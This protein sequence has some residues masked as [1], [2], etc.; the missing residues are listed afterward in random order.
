MSAGEA[1]TEGLAAPET[2]RR[3][4][5]LWTAKEALSKALRCGLTCPVELLATEGA[6]FRGDAVTG[7]FRNFGQYRF[8]SVLA[9]PFA[10]SIVL[11][12]SSSLSPGFAP[13]LAGRLG[14]D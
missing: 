4:T 1:E 6:A 13:W 9:G 7:R 11:P 8:E 14:G 2:L 10:F 3:V 12:R 5:Q